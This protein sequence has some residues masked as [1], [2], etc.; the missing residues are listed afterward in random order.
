VAPRDISLRDV[1]ATPGGGFAI[2]GDYYAS[3]WQGVLLTSPDGLTWAADPTG[4]AG[5][6]HASPRAF[7]ASSGPGIAMALGF[8]GTPGNGDQMQGAWWTTDGHSWQPSVLSLTPDGSE[9]DDVAQMASGDLIGVGIEPTIWR[10]TL[11]PAGP[12]AGP[13]SDGARVPATPGGRLDQV[14]YLLAHAPDLTRCSILTRAE[15]TLRHPEATAGIECARVGTLPKVRYYLFP[16]RKAMAAWWSRKLG[17]A[18]TTGL[19]PDSG[20]FEGCRAG[21]VGET[22]WAAGTDTGRVACYLEAGSGSLAGKQFAN[23]RWT[24]DSQLI[25]AWALGS[26][27]NLATLFEGFAEGRS[28]R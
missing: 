14:A 1:M 3:D 23:L 2:V 9:M 10:G 6:R 8:V 5:P 17:D 25:G 11:E 26:D 24:D 16:D 27:D 21:S 20:S 4:L 13:D 19:Q 12:P 18:G 28:Q 22:G 7:G 15:V